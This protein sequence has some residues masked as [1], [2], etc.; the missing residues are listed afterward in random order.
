MTSYT[1]ILTLDLDNEWIFFTAKHIVTN[2]TQRNNL[3]IW[4]DILVVKI[5]L[6]ANEVESFK[7]KYADPYLPYL[8]QCFGSTRLVSI[9]IFKNISNLPEYWESK[10]KSYCISADRVIISYN[11]TKNF[12]IHFILDTY[13]SDN[14]LL[15]VS[16]VANISQNL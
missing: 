12:H 3:Y 15:P 13:Y 9:C 1:S 2:S 4:Y 16:F 6:I 11:Q 14:V 7:E 5:W 10:K 8:N